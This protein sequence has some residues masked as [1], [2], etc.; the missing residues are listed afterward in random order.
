MTSP[1]QE[2][3]PSWQEHFH[4]LF[5]VRREGKMLSLDEARRAVS[6]RQLV[7]AIMSIDQLSNDEDRKKVHST[8]VEM[9]GPTLL[10]QLRSGIAL[11]SGITVDSYTLH[12]LAPTTYLETKISMRE[13]LTDLAKRDADIKIDTLRTIGRPVDLTTATGCLQNGQTVVECSLSVQMRDGRLFAFACLVDDAELG[14]LSS[15]FNPKADSNVLYYELF[16]FD[17]QEDL[18]QAGAI[19]RRR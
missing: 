10:Q 12:Q 19:L 11:P 1:P 4:N 18:A 13:L 2:P 5:V 16:A 15:Q 17:T 6:S 8:I 7:V 3:A 9:V 14:T